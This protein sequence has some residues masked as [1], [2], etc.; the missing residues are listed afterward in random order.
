M[1]E[2]PTPELAVAIL[3][4]AGE[5]S[6]YRHDPD[7]P[8]MGSALVTGGAVSGRVH[9]FLENGR[10]L[11][12]RTPG[13]AFYYEG[14]L[15]TDEGP[16]SLGA[17][18][19][20]PGGDGACTADRTPGESAL[21]EARAVRI[22]AEPFGGSPFGATTVAEGALLWLQDRR[23]AE[24]GE[25]EV[26]AEPLPFDGLTED[27]PVASFDVPEAAAQPQPTPAG[28][29]EPG[30]RAMPAP[31]E[32][33]GPESAPSWTAP[34]PWAATAALGTQPVWGAFP[35]WTV[36]PS[37]PW[38]S[39]AAQAVVQTTMQMP[40][41]AALQP[42]VPADG[43]PAGEPSATG[44]PATAVATEAPEQGETAP[45]QESS[46]VRMEELRLE[47][48]AGEAATPSG[49]LTLNV[50]LVGRH[51]MAPRAA[52]HIVIHKQSGSLA[53]TVRGLPT[54]PSL[55]RDSTTDRPFNAYRVWLVQPRTGAKLSL[56]HCTRVWGDNFRFES[57]SSL[58][59]GRY[60]TIL[61]T[62]DDRTAASPNPAAPQ[63]LLGTYAGFGG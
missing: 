1:N 31:S 58:P 15:M 19:A 17:F 45:P 14:W 27:T 61:I 57:E 8:L 3:T 21:P 13:G 50:P 38:S 63:V 7:R 23:P 32:P 44:V 30:A 10:P 34:A 40:H 4:E 11:S 29:A 46:S 25:A 5:G 43:S 2:A 35:P 56:G 9:L 26:R 52:G 54:P 41:H 53:I 39:P 12:G 16:V 6:A 20:G 18:N 51:P 60:D 37:A 62:A 47:P 48:T 55:G 28:D 24:S 33:A 36:A 42:D 49:S 22:T 59:L